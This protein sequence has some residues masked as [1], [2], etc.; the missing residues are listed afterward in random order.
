MASIDLGHSVVV[1]APTGSGKTLIA[2]HAIDRVREKGGRAF[3]TTPIKALSNQK[4]R[5][6]GERYGRSEVGL[7]TGDNSINGD[8]PIIVMTTEVLRNMLYGGIGRVDDV[9]TVVLDEVHYLEDTYRGPVWEEV[10]IHL[11]ETARLVCLS[12]T[13]SNAD[14]LGSWIGSVHGATD[15]IVE[16]RRPVALDNHYLVG[17]RG[18]GRLRFLPLLV[19][20]NPN[21]DG[22]RYD[23][24]PRRV[25]GRSS[26]PRWMTP[27]RVE[28]LMLLQQRALLPAI[29]FLFSRT[30]C[31]E[32]VQACRREGIHLTDHD[33]R[34]RIREIAEAHTDA[35][36]DR[37]RLVLG[38]DRWLEALEAGVA[39]H[40]AGLVP[41]FKEAV[42]ACFVEGLVKAVFA[43]ETLALGINMPARAVVIERLT[44]WTGDRHDFLTPSQY[45]Q[46][47][48]RAGRRGIDDHGDAVVLWSP[49][50]PF[51]RVATLAKSRE[52]RLRS[53]F[54]PTYNMAA[55]LVRR[56]DPVEAHRLLSSSFGQWQSAQEQRTGQEGRQRA[57]E[58]P[59]REQGSL[60]DEFER[61][62]GVLEARGHLSGW[63]LT[64]SG[65]RLARL[66]HECDLLLVEA[67]AAGLAEGLDS[68]ELAAFVSCLTFERREPG[69]GDESEL[70]TVGL[71]ERWRSLDRLWEDLERDEQQARL[72]PTRRPDPGFATTAMAWATGY[73]LEEILEEGELSGGDFVRN[74]KQLVD[75]LRQVGDVAADPHTARAARRATEDL[76]RGVVAI[77][78]AVFEETG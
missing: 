21:P 8:A 28:V 24:D 46:L 27:S 7:L 64:D 4:Y 38:F 17:E 54:R 74:V 45:S 1:A 23:H 65:E 12:A 67:L 73:G 29:Y 55:N 50:V 42:E 78:S 68:A 75:L 76:V 32:A 48:G 47:T 13:I 43:T 72:L 40:H 53:A 31:D 6:L 60:A 11:P 33:E 51:R 25:R 63:A 61:V 49:W 69:H 71:A 15:V 37:D 59:A 62:L 77:S 16:H 39:A 34:D 14:E 41:P 36:G 58:R 70:P 57:D 20:G 66:Y 26:R 2:E 3:Y 22:T 44:K 56:H 30:G 52:F 9:A 19:D 10:I 18:S 5:D 35:L